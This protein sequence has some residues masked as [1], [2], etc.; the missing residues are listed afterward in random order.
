[1]EYCQE[2]HPELGAEESRDPFHKLLDMLPRLHSED[3][4]VLQLTLAILDQVIQSLCFI[5]QS[6]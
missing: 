4:F 6:D 1:M 3:P 5:F 2:I